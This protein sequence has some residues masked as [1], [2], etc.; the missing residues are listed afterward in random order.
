MLPSHPMPFNP[1]TSNARPGEQQEKIRTESVRDPNAA[2]LVAQPSSNTIFQP[3][4]LAGSRAPGLQG[5]GMMDP[6]PSGLQRLLQAQFKTS[7][8][9]PLDAAPG[10]AQNPSCVTSALWC[11]SL[12]KVKRSSVRRGVMSHRPVG[13]G[14]K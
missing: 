1:S 8:P 3:Q 12:W 4:N 14:A 9:I 7:S 2:P 5:S 13:P 10:P 6:H 11:L